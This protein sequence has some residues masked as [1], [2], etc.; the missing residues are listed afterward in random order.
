MMVSSTK[1]WQAS[2]VA[3]HW[4]PSIPSSIIFTRNPEDLAKRCSL[5]YGNWKG[6]EIFTWGHSHTLHFYLLLFLLS[7]CK[8][9]EDSHCLMASLAPLL[10]KFRELRSNRKGNIV[11]A[12]KGKLSSIWVWNVFSHIAVLVSLMLP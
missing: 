11:Y 12:A 4:T 5:I 8:F 9:V 2:G 7:V 6:N 1:Y 10:I 3:V